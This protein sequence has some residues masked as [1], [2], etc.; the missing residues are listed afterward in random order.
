V[1][2]PLDTTGIGWVELAE[3]KYSHAYEL[4]Q[5]REQIT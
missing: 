3:L 2:D 1:H 4:T 5:K